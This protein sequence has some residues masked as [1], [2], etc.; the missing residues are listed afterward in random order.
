[1]GFEFYN[2]LVS[3]L[4]IEQSPIVFVKIILTIVLLF[5]SAMLSGAEVALFSLKPSTLESDKGEFD[6]TKK[7]I[8]RLL[9]SPKRLLATILVTI[10]FINIGIVLLFASLTDVFLSGISSYIFKL[11]LEI[12]FITIIILFFGEILP[13]IYANRNSLIFSKIV[14][15]PLFYLDKYLLWFLT[16]PMSKI[17]LFI[18]NR[19]GNKSNSFTVG[20]LSKAL[21]YT[22]QKD[23]TKQ[24]D[25]ILKGIVSFGNTD[26]K[27]VMCPR[28]DVFALSEK[29]TL[30]EILPK[31]IKAGFS[32]IPVYKEKIDA[33]S[34]I[35]YVKDL[36]PKINSSS[37]S[38]QKLI[39]EPYYVP[40]NKKLDDLFKEFQIKKIHLAIVVDEY[41]GTSGIVTLED[42]IEE[43][44]GDISDEYDDQEFEYTRIDEKNLL[45]DAKM[46]LKDFY[47][48][49]KLDSIEIFEKYKGESE[50][51]AGFLLEIVQSFPKVGQKIYFEK[52]IFKIEY[53]EQRRIKKIK[54]T[55]P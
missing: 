29:L 35:L 49:L 22:E 26:T 23:M 11:V 47:R 14:A 40:E 51:L 54:V 32:R 6:K 17:T 48:L 34:G 39:R 42:I 37:F 38:W 30:K 33:I 24:E 50:T 1:M 28:I 15:Y 53:I 20:E 2:F 4:L 10:N 25:K 9:K 44:V 13:K 31:I 3:F 19:F 8:K 43:I 52:Y 21:E 41:G 27:Q 55:I 12:G 16:R 5:F 45:V 36:M 46:N 7:L 18:E